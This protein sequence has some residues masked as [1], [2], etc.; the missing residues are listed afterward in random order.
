M[1]RE[2]LEAKVKASCPADI[3]PDL[4]AAID[5]IP[6][7]CLFELIETYQEESDQDL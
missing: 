7:Q 6:D 2:E 5:D 3:L 4:L 1:E